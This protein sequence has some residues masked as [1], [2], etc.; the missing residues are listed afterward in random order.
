MLGIGEGFPGSVRSRV[1]GRGAL[2]MVIIQK[3]SS[4]IIVGYL[5]EKWNTP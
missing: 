5:F 2:S 4:L 1:V 3:A